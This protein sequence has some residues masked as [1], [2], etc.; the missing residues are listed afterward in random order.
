MANAI[1]HQQS[2]AISRRDCTSRQR[3]CTAGQTVLRCLGR[4]PQLAMVSLLFIAGAA[5]ASPLSVTYPNLNGNGTANLGYRVLSLALSKT[6]E[7]YAL[8]LHPLAVNDERARAMLVNGGIDVTDFA[9]AAHLEN[10][11]V[12]PIDNPSATPAFLGIP[13]KYFYQP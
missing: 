9:A 10:R 3:P 8:Y 7:P 11:V 5:L 4:L 2:V 13:R 12:I 1:Q 6:G